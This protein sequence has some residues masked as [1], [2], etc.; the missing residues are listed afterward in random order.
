VVPLVEDCFLLLRFFVADFLAIGVPLGD[1]AER[2][3]KLCL[4]Q[5]CQDTLKGRQF[6]TNPVLF[7]INPIDYPS[8]G[9]DSPAIQ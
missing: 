2:S 3:V 1:K 8:F 9:R 7:P 6:S 5:K 4:I